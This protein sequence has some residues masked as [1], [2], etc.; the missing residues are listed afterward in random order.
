MSLKVRKVNAEVRD[1]E[2]DEMI[3]AG[4]LGSDALSTIEEAK[5]DALEAIQQKGEDTLESIPE[6]YTA[7]SGDVGELKTQIKAD[8]LTQNNVIIYDGTRTLAGSA[9]WPPR[10]FTKN[11]IKINGSFSANADDYYTMMGGPERYG[12]T[13]RAVNGWNKN[14]PL[15]G[16]HIYKFTGMLL[17][18]SVTIPEGENLTYNAKDSANNIVLT[19]GYNETVIFTCETSGN[20]LFYF[21]AQKSMAFTDAILAYTLVDITETETLKEDVASLDNEN[22]LNTLNN[23]S[24]NIFSK[25]ATDYITSKGYSGTT[26]NIVDAVNNLITGYIPV[27]SGDGVQCYVNGKNITNESVEGQT[28]KIAVYDAEKTWK[29]TEI[30]N[31]MGIEYYPITENGFVRFMLRRTDYIEVFVSSITKKDNLVDLIVFAGQSNM[32]GRGETSTTYPE[33]APAVIPGAGYEFK[34]VTDPTKLYPIAEP[35][36]VSENNPGGDS[37]GIDDGNSK[38]GDMVPAFINAYYKHNAGV[39]VVGVS[40]SEGGSSSVEWLP[41]TG[42]NFVDLAAR[43]D[44]ARKWLVDNGYS[45]RYQY[46]V[47]CQGESD[48]DNVYSGTETLAEYETRARAIFSGLIALGLEKVLLVRIG[49]YNGNA[50]GKSYTAIID[51]QTE[52]AQ[53]NDA[54]V[55]VSCDFAGMKTSG[56]MKDDFHYYQ[57]GYNIA[58]NSAGINSAFYATTGKEPTMFDPENDNLYYSHKN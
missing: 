3:P 43:L 47:W 28:R 40:A 52:E 6:D 37:S 9:S 46:C 55:M 27:K 4:L 36:G 1:P 21:H 31:N 53:T 25:Y 2:T 26:G 33:T 30:V 49:N 19:C 7:L 35:F 5:E 10:T 11:L 34:S 15:A 50:T 45:I 16:G 22:I 57:I 18:G 17:S 41:E 39:P 42:N 38:T 29:K 24:A 20:F 54:L 44:T 56:M 8:E 23:Y 14:I 51:W 58:G 32:A 13:T 12:T 48:G